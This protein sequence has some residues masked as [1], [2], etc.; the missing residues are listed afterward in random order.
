MDSVNNA[1]EMLSKIKGRK[2]FIFADIL[3]LD[4]Y[5][6]EIHEKIGK[7]ILNNNI[8]VLICV[9]K[10]AKETYNVVYKNIS[11]YHFDN[12]D[13]MKK[14]LDNIIHNG[15]TILIKGSHGMNLTEIVEY[16]KKD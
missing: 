10:N 4:E 14:V 7:S 15:D 8:N 13:D 5:A 11:S 12:N 1:L 2:V 9:G 6:K 16:L 3:E